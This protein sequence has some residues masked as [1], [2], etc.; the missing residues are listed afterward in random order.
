M[1]RTDYI[2]PFLSVIL[3]WLLRGSLDCVYGQVLPPAPA[4]PPSVIEQQLEN[5]TESSED[6]VTE[7]DSYLQQLVY[8]IK[9]PLNLNYADEGQLQELR[10]L[11]PLQ[12]SNLISYR[13]L[14]GNFINIYELQAI[15]NWDLTL[16]KRILPY[17]TVIP[18]VDIFN[19][20]GS[21]L[22]NGENTLMLTGTRVLEKSKGYL[23]DSS[24]ATNF[25]PGSPQKILL[26]YRY[27]F[28]NLLQY[29]ITG[30]KDAGEQFFRGAQKDGFDF[31][32]AHF[33]VRNLG[34]IKSLA[35]GDFTVNL[36]QGLT[37]WQG[38]AFKKS[39]DVLNILKG[40]PMF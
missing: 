5:L 18:R 13:N 35:I 32:S 39:S 14:L 31:Y 7:D 22:K 27:M 34:I 1:K 19:S 30:E 37:Q 12:I 15:P 8:F 33:F 10:L 36:G 2:K 6:V 20:L 29:G 28:K 11:S 17:V 21:R 26:R 25:Y 9:E 3:Y 23:L 40:N 24:D 38:L 16:I 4:E